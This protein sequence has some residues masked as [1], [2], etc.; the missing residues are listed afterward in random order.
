MHWRSLGGKLRMGSNG[1]EALILWSNKALHRYALPEGG[2]VRDTVSGPKP[3]Y[4]KIVGRTCRGALWQKGASSECV[5]VS[6]ALR[7]WLSR[8]HPRNLYVGQLRND[9]VAQ[10]LQA[11]KP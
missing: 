7:P 1:P 8:A 9:R 10:N 5:E 4:P 11:L 6:E 2:Q 3:L